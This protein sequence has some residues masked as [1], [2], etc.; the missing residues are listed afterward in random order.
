MTNVAYN[1]RRSNTINTQ[2]REIAEL[3]AELELT[4]TQLKLREDEVNFLR[5]LVKK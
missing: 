5:E 4:R 1:S 2:A 3:K